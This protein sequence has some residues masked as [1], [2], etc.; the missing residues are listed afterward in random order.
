MLCLGVVYYLMMLYTGHYYLQGVGYAAIV[1]VLAGLI[2]NP[3]FL[4]FLFFGKMFATSLTLGSG[5]SGG[6]FSPSLFLGAMLGAFYGKMMVLMFP[7]MGVSPV[8]FA[9]A[10]MGGMV[11]GTTGAVL[12][13]ICMLFEMTRD[14]NAILPVMLTVGMAY[15][16]RTLIRSE[17]I[18]TLKLLR[19]GHHVHEGLQS[20][21]QTA[22]LA[23]HIMNCHF[24]MV[25][26]AEFLAEP[27]LYTQ[28]RKADDV[29]IISRGSEVGGIL[30]T[31]ASDLTVRD[32][33]ISRYLLV[34]PDTNLVE[35]QRLLK[36]HNL[37]H[38]LVTRKMEDPHPNQIIGVITPEALLRVSGHTS[39]LMH[40]AY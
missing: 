10:G 26:Q 28:M 6:V 25:P 38:A 16:T 11:S 14:Y 13:A 24:T 15:F 35:L 20:A 40:E 33:L 1:D 39:E 18:Y 34:E 5:A 12:T 19:R 9:V 2:S 8:M 3:W 22:W 36:S 27:E 17:S 29:I 30:R 21:F 32:A 7:H 23:R 37:T 31:G 4:L